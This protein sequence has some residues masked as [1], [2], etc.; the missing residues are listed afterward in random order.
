MSTLYLP[1]DAVTA[2]CPIDSKDGITVFYESKNIIYSVLLSS[3][4]N[5][6]ARQELF[7][8]PTNAC[9]TMLRL[10]DSEILVLRKMEVTEKVKELGLGGANHHC[11]LLNE[12]TGKMTDYGQIEP[13]EG[14]Y[15]VMN[16]RFLQLESGR[17]VLSHA[18]HPKADY[19]KGLETAGVCFTSYSDDQGKTW[20]QSNYLKASSAKG[21]LAEPMVVES[22]HSCELFMFMRNSTGYLH[23]SV[24]TD[25]GET[26]QPEAATEIRMPCAPF[27][28]K[29][30]PF[31]GYAFLVW[32]NAFPAHPAH[33]YPRSPICLAVSRD[34]TQSWEFITEIEAN[35][36]KSY[37]YPSLY[38]TK[39]EIKVFFY[40]S[41]DRSFNP[42]E[43][44]Q[45][46]RTYKRGELSVAKTIYEPLFISL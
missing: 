15:Y 14:C 32:D 30:D 10:S 22:D 24:S 33:Q 45:K 27:C 37:G 4:N 25:N 35:P 5:F 39:D 26:W 43:Q 21:H 11:L 17:V 16:D 31:S 1:D 23:K 12:V 7:E 19:N 6:S 44:K 40:E 29:K 34:N 46:I 38:F 18:Q 42:P 36:D 28:V 20:K 2:A 9:V 8:S 13:E 41:S 3:D